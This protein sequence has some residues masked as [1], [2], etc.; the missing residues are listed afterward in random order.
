VSEYI[1]IRN[2]E[3]YQRI[4][5]N[6]AP[7][8][9]VQTDIL[10]DIEF[11]M[12]PDRERLCFLLLLCLAGRTKNKIPSDP[13]AIM[14]ICH[15]DEECDISVMIDAGLVEEWNEDEHGEGA[16]RQQ[17]TRQRARERKAKSRQKCD[18]SCDNSVTKCDGHSMSHIET[19]RETDT[20]KKRSSTKPP[21]DGASV[22]RFEKWWDMYG[23]KRGR[24]KAEKKFI[25]LGASAQEECLRVVEAYV[26]STPDVQYR[27]DPCTY[28]NGRH[29]ED[30]VVIS[31]KERAKDEARAPVNL[32]C[33]E[34]GR[35]VR[36]NESCRN[37][38]RYCSCGGSFRRVTI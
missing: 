7:F 34:C 24:A 3:K 15:C 32:K 5:G 20:K 18:V 1:R 2:W 26:R 35:H 27:K 30:E 37:Q 25:S 19:E 4:E 21:V 22:E 10:L 38:Y 12:L 13:K 17:V 14:H 28:L 11:M 9:Q 8:V 16:I 33:R 36:T 6:K 31:A 23:K 29:W